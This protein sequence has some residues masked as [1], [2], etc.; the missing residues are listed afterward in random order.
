MWKNNE[1]QG[2]I[3]EH[4]LAKP[5]RPHLTMR[6][7]DPRLWCHAVMQR[8]QTIGRSP[9]HDIVIPHESVSRLHAEICRSGSQV[10]L[11]D[12]GSLNGTYVNG[13]RV[14]ERAVVTIGD[15]IRLGN[16]TLDLNRF[17]H[18][19]SR[20]TEEQRVGSGPDG[21]V[22]RLSDQQRT[23]LTLLLKGL[24]EKQVAAHMGLSV[25]TVHIH[26]HNLYRIFG[27][28]SRPELL[29]RLLGGTSPDIPIPQPH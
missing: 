20:T 29:A 11:R 28:H 23:V 7:I 18:D 25:H 19:E 15:V 6:G 17:Q 26:I 24:S 27:V 9:L 14:F 10:I 2:S 22:P 13:H 8:P 1:Q 16:V 5:G 3:A 4:A 12:H 21:D